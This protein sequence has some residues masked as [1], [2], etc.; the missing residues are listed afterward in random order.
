MID[1]EINKDNKIAYRSIFKAT[2]LFGGVQV[3]NIIIQIIKQKFIAILLGPTG[4]GISGLYTSAISLIQGI[5]SMGLSLSPVKDV[6]EANGTG[7]FQRISKIVTTVRKLV[8]ITGLLGMIIVI[9]L[10]PLL[11][12]STFGNY[13]YT[14]PFIF[15]SVTLLFQ[16][17]SIGQ[18]VVLQ[19]MRKLKHLAKSSVLGSFF[20][21]II[22][23]PIYYYF[24][25]EGIVPTLI[26]SSIS[27]LLLTW[28]FSKKIKIVKQKATVKQTF[29]EGKEML[30]MGLALSLTSIFATIIGYILRVFIVRI[31]GTDDVGFYTA[32]FALVNGYVGLIFNSMGT[33]YYPRLAK[34]NKDNIK[35]KEVINQQAEIAIL[36]ISPIIII[37]LIL[38]PFFVSLL[39]SEKFYSIT[40]FIQ[41]S[42]FGM[43]LRAA[44]W[45][46]SYLLIAKGEKRLFVV[47]EIIAN[48]YIFILNILFYYIWGLDGLGIAFALSYFIFLIQY[49][50]VSKIKFDFSFTQ[51]F[52]KIFVFEALMLFVCLILM[53][54]FKTNYIYIPT[55]IIG[56]ICF[57]FSFKELDKRMDLLKTI[58]NKL[59]NH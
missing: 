34:I 22:S 25:I 52:K 43:I 20:G 3:F 56:L 39:Y 35:C 13:D 53:L 30:K 23:V 26:L 19:G 24:G 46:I 31:G 47:N 49:F 37:F 33:D 11:S 15:L 54:S 10:S 2:S 12:K 59:D 41:W 42:M 57:L 9:A 18:S 44:G 1:I 29:A 5:T 28:Y 7:D 6:A 27:T 58:K 40:V 21:L 50:M 45:S 32:G 4:M 55:A 36:I 14:I 38:A 8:W 51:S 48:S 16:Q 17:L